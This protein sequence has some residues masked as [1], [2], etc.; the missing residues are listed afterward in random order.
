MP[1]VHAR[2]LATLFVVL[3]EFVCALSANAQNL[4]LNGDFEAPPHDPL[5][6]ILN[7]SIGGPGFVHSAAQGAT[8]G[9]FSA[10]LSI[11]SDTQ[12]NVLFQTFATTI[13][14][15]YVVDFDSGVFGIRSGN[16]LRL[17]LNIQVLGNGTLLEQT[18]TPPE[19]LTNVPNQ[20]VFNHYRFAFTANSATTTLAFTDIGLGNADA[21][22]EID[23]VSVLP[24][25]IPAPT[26]LPLTNANFENGP[27]NVNGTVTGWTATGNPSV[28]ILPEG[29]TTGTHSAAFS[30]GGDF[31]NTML[32]QRFFTTVGR[33]YSVDFDSAVYGITGSTQGLRV[34][35]VGSGALLDQFITPPYFETFDTGIIQ[36]QHYH[37]VF[38]ADSAV[39]TL[40]FTQFGFDNLNA[41]V[42]LDTV[43]IAPVGL[44]F[45]EWQ[46]MHFDAGQLNN[47]SISGWSADPDKDQVAN[48]LEYFCNADPL[49]GIPG[50]DSSL[51]PHAAIETFDS[52]RYLTL[53]YHRR[54]GFSG[55]P[56]VVAVS[57]DLF[58]WDTT[59]AQIVPVSVTPS[60]DGITEV[61]KV[62]LTI[63]ID[64]VPP[65]RK[66]LRLSV[67]Q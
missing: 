19:A 10:A 42:V 20:V 57:D 1:T 39:S 12:G 41:D 47:P 62:R 59:G 28:S 22:I 11:G 48:G 58:S 21:D 37:F 27:F 44:T 23:T 18:M 24:T 38:V 2:L 17:R 54:I 52:S 60:G 25:T 26:V 13:G 35:V 66:F 55:N 9:N 46:A 50:Q 63:S 51:M 8:S 33:Q 40:A 30:S 64:Q 7:W 15:D 16:Q 31:Q 14:Q 29:S 32:S 36:L 53:T 65:R 3:I 34:S 67:T 49:T 61:V 56:E 43:A 5:A 6:A 45:A 4:V